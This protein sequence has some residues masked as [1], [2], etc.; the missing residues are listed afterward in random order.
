[1]SSGAAARCGAL[2]PKSRAACGR[3]AGHVGACRSVEAYARGRRQYNQRRADW[4]LAARERRDLRPARGETPAERL[5]A[6]AIA[7]DR[8]L[9]LSGGLRGN[10]ADAFLTRESDRLGLLGRAVPWTPFERAWRL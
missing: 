4:A 6:Y 3:G 5:L 10:A 2:M 7:D 9:R 1:M 8:G